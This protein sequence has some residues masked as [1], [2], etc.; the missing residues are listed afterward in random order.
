MVEGENNIWRK[1]FF[2]WFEQLEIISVLPGVLGEPRWT[3]DYSKEWETVSNSL[4]VG[5][6]IVE[7]EVELEVIVKVAI[8]VVIL[9]KDTVKVEVMLKV[10]VE[11]SFAVA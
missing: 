3:S 11:I 1:Y 10:E 9:L 7:V 6:T 2:V 8:E 5:W 4:A